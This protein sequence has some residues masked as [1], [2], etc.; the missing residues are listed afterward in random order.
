MDTDFLEGNLVKCVT[1]LTQLNFQ[2]FHFSEI[3]KDNI[4]EYNG[5]FI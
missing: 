4:K 5:I 3:F 2:R 1:I